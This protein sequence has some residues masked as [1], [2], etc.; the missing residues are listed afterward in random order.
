MDAL[1]TE[2]ETAKANAEALNTE[3]ETAKAKLT[4]IEDERAKVAQ[5]ETFK[6]RFETLP[7]A[8]RAAFAKRSEDERNRFEAKWAAAAEAEWEEFRKD[9][10]LVVGETRVSYLNLSRKEGPLPGGW[11]ESAEAHLKS[12][13]KSTK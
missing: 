9:V 3:L 4:E 11:S 2:F 1:K 10:L 8:Y 13:L 6:K 7:E 5:A 12:L